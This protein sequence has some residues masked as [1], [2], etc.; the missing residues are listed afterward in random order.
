MKLIEHTSVQFVAI[1]G[2]E[3]ISNLSGEQQLR[4]SLVES[5]VRLRSLAPDPG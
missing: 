5:S 4:R 2:Q 1:D 3:N